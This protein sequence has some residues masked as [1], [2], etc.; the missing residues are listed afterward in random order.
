MRKRRA[1]NRLTSSAVRSLIRE[2]KSGYHCDGAGL[3]L[4]VDPN[5]AARWAFVYRWRD[6][7]E[8]P[9]AGRRREMGLGSITSVNLQHARQMA[10]AA[11]KARA[12]GVDPLAG[13]GRRPARTAAS[14]AV[15]ATVAP[16]VERARRPAPVRKT[17][18]GSVPAQPRSPSSIPLPS[19]ARPRRKPPK[20]PMK[21]GQL[22]MFGLED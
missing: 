21:T 15:S 3:Y 8:G 2:S 14:Q 13:P 20:Q 16:A 4:V 6:N 12:D 1:S 22:D 19:T 11:R 7:P 5:G 10:S 18:G 9:G 17:D